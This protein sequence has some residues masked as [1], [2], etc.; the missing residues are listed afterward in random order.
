[1]KFSCN[2]TH[3][4]RLCTVSSGAL[5][6]AVAV[7]MSSTDAAAI[8]RYQSTS[9]SCSTIKAKIRGEG[10]VILQHVS[11]S[12]GNLLYNRYVRND[13]YCNIY[14]TTRAKCVP[15]ADTQSCLVY[16]CVNRDRNCSPFGNNC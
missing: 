16:Y 4:R 9:L 15:A 8:S 2:T 3:R 6:I 10:A 7:S 11:K 14:Q 13:N 12:T 1:M 5:I